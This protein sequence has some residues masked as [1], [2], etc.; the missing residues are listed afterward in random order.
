[1]AMRRADSREDR[2]QPEEL[3]IFFFSLP[4]S[5]RQPGSDDSFHTLRIAARLG[6]DKGWVQR[7]EE[8][9]KKE[10]TRHEATTINEPGRKWSCMISIVPEWA[11][12]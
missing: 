6:F 7:E 1:M 12:G 11:K 9:R 3:R 2:S 10:S 4:F 5:P 8:E